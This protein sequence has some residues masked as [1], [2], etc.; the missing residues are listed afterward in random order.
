MVTASILGILVLF[1]L[2]ALATSKAT[3]RHKADVLERRIADNVPDLA[4]EDERAA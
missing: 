1:I 3:R 2:L 4:E